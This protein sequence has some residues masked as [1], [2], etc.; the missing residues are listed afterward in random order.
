MCWDDTRS[1]TILKGGQGTKKRFAFGGDKL[2]NFTPSSTLTSDTKCWDETR[3]TLFTHGTIVKFWQNA[4]KKLDTV[5]AWMPFLFFRDSKK[6]T[7]REPVIISKLRRISKLARSE[8]RNR[9]RFFRQKENVSKRSLS[10]FF[11]K[12]NIFVRRLSHVF[13]MWATKKNA[14]SIRGFTWTRLEI[15]YP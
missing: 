8:G 4:C 15:T 1:G 9:K 7:S 11:C 10:V 14:W 13:A 12:E 2:V 3:S 6:K 5:C